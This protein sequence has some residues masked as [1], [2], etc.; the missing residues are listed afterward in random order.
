MKT[1]VPLFQVMIGSSAILLLV[2]L[3]SSS[4][5]NL[6]V[7]MPLLYFAMNVL[8]LVFLSLLP[9][10]ML[11]DGAIDGLECS[12]LFLALAVGLVV[13]G[14]LVLGLAVSSRLIFDS[15]YSFR[16][17]ATASSL[18][19]LVGYSIMFWGLHRQIVEKRASRA[20]ASAF[21][22]TNPRHFARLLL[23][24]SLFV[25][26]PLAVLFLS[27]NYD[28]GAGVIIFLVGITLLGLRLRAWSISNPGL[29]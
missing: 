20:L 21:D 13:G 19:F 24:L 5:V 3:N 29:A 28:L 22:A 7:D 25:S 11:R 18:A 6:T 23:S 4:V 9:H 15:F 2:I 8:G 10:A 16:L 12:R 14:F 27:S 1:L 17:L 26:F